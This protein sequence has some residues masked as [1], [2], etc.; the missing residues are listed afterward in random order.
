LQ[1]IGFESDDLTGWNLAGQNLS[2]ANLAGTKLIGDNL[3]GANFTNA[4][5]GERPLPTPTFAGPPA[6]R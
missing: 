2:N 5:T 1:G 6:L 4:K 3:Q